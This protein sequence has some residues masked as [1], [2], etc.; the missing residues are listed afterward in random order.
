LSIKT[1]HVGSTAGLAAAKRGECDVAGIHLL[2]PASGEYNRPFLSDELE[3]V[4]GYRRCQSFVF[5]PGD[6]RFTGKSADEAVAAARA[7]PACTMVNRNAGSGTRILI[8]QLLENA[9]VGRTGSPSASGDRVAAA[10]ERTDYQSVLRT[11]PPGYGVQARSHN[12]VAAAVAQGRADWGLAIDTVARQYGLAAI[13][14]RDEHYDFVVPR[15]RGERTAV[16]RFCALLRD[17]SVRQ[18]LAGR[19]FGV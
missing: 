18:H 11:R 12:A 13:P 6:P 15:S 17:H 3:F 7:D 9:M 5:R 2:D 16:Q 1:M 4:P 14:V 10:P 19:G 8:D